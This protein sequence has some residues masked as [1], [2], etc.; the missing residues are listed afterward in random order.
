MATSLHKPMNI[1]IPQTYEGEFDSKS[2]LEEDNE[3]R[4]DA[5]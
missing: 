2:E 5:S 4:S 1:N 3:D